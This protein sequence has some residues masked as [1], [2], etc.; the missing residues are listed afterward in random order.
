MTI[1]QRV[2]GAVSRTETGRRIVSQ[3]AYRV[4]LAAT[5]SLAVN[6]VFALYHGVVGGIQ[7]SLWLVAMCAYYTV[8]S[9]VRFCAVLYGRRESAAGSPGGQYFVMKATG[10]LLVLL[11]F[12]LTGVITVSISQNIAAKYDTIT[13]LTIATFTF[14][15]ITMTVVR[16]VRLRRTPSPVLASLCGIGCA[17]AAASLL[18]LQRSMLVSFGETA[19]T[20]VW[21][22]ATGAGVCLFVL[23]LGIA[24]AAKGAKK[25]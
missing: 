9:V 5:A 12:V 19:D 25:G 2:L 16:A 6:L 10:L 15:K 14:G 7:R 3:P 24:M 4:V 1:R 17:E 11:S 13:M 22:A 18:T 23:S 20:T 21:N 8:F